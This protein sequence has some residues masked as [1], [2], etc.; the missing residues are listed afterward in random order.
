MN[1]LKEAMN[2][3]NDS[4]GFTVSNF[5]RLMELREAAKG[6]EA[7]LIGKLVET[8]IMQAPPSVLKEI[9]GMV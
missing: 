5:E 4:S 3:V 6:E 2:L 1:Y 8:F 7:A 9:V